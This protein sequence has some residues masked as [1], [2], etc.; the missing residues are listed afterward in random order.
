[1]IKTSFGLVYMCRYTKLRK[2]FLWS[3]YQFESNRHIKKLGCPHQFETKLL[4]NYSSPEPTNWKHVNN[5]LYATGESLGN[6]FLKVSFI[7]FSCNPSENILRNVNFFRINFLQMKQN[8]T[9]LLL[10]ETEYTS[11]RTSCRTTQNLES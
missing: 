7:I 5:K 2:Y 1:M 10:P 8:G 3:N 4:S 11:C 9:R 6:W